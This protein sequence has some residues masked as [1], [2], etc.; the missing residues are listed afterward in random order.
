MAEVNPHGETLEANPRMPLE[1]LERFMTDV[2]IGAGVPK[3]DAEA[4]G[5]VLIAADRR[6]MD[7]HGI[8]RLKLIYYDRIMS[9]Q[10]SPITNFEV[11]RESPTTAVVDG[12]NGM[13][14]V[15]ATRCMQMAIDKAKKF[16]MGMV[17]ARNSTHYG[18][19]G[20]YSLMAAEQGCIGMNG[21]NA[22]P[23]VCPTFAV[24]PMLGTNP[25]VF[26]FPT[27]EGFAWCLDCAT[28]VVQ[29]GKIEMYAREKKPV[30]E[31]WVINER[32]DFVTDTTQILRDLTTGKASCLPI[33]G[34]GEDLGGYKGYG[35]ATAVEI[36]SSCLQA[37][38]FMLALTGTKDGKKVP[39]ELGHFF[40][41]VNIEAFRDANEFKQ[42]VGEVCRT[43]RSAKKAPGIE[44]IWTAGEKEHYTELFRKAHGVA[45]PA[46]LR[47]EME[48]LRK[49]LNLSQWHFPWDK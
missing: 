36:L 45:I 19:A 24:E 20:Y 2:L 11:V 7:T 25:L 29:R 49:E 46:G 28:S 37:G 1:E 41:A 38:N 10:L 6:G 4:C 22:R 43:L 18:I 34:A 48:Q 42:Q 32:G 3:A 35:F 8:Q 26:A 23:S 33:G 31:G 12:H 47:P 14:M 40:L 44:R 21:T 15:I 27:D 13:G 39:I 5:K 17:V 16:G 30:P 9:K